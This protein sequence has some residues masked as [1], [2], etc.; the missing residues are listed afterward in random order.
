MTRRVRFE[1]RKS[2]LAFICGGIVIKLTTAELEV[3]VAEAKGIL[4][5]KA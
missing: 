2:G 5:E 1:R 3:L 4:E